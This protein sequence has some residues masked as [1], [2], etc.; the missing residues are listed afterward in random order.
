MYVV[1]LCAIVVAL[2][3]VFTLIRQSL[4]SLINVPRQLMQLA[5]GA[6]VRRNHAIEHATANVLEER[7]GSQAIDGCATVEGFRIVAAVDPVLLLDAAREGLLRL[8]R[9]D[10][11][12]ALHKRCS[13][14]LL[15]SYTIVTG[16]L[17]SMLNAAHAVTIPNLSL[18]LI[19]AIASTPKL[20]NLMQRFVTTSTDVK[21]MSIGGVELVPP[22]MAMGFATPG[23]VEFAIRTKPARRG[24]RTP[25]Q[26]NEHAHVHVP[27]E[28][29]RQK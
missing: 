22:T 17:L 27:V 12:L 1:V 3:L 10:R 23:G 26:F 11:A 20:S 19:I 15:L 9:G 4:W 24:Y 14:T 25:N 16:L 5:H 2:A 7:Y 13:T 18:V 8:Q 29:Q 28:N 6:M 21:G